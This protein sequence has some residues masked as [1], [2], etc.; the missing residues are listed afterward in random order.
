MPHRVAAVF[1]GQNVQFRPF[2]FR[3]LGPTIRRRTNEIGRRTQSRLLRPQ[4]GRQL[5]AD[6]AVP[7][8]GSLVLIAGVV[9]EREPECC[10]IVRHLDIRSYTSARFRRTVQVS[11]ATGAGTRLSTSGF[12]RQRFGRIKRVSVSRIPAWR[13]STAG[14]GTG[15]R[16]FPSQNGLAARGG[17]F[18]PDGRRPSM[19]WPTWSA[20]SAAA[21]IRPR[22]GPQSAG[23]SPAARHTPPLAAGPSSSRARRGR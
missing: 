6:I 5:P 15:S 23:R 1:P 18:R 4:S 21:G 12:P 20:L 17:R 13:G 7:K 14:G 2:A 3:E 16:N 22:S 9:Q 8:P 10:V 11:A 19:S